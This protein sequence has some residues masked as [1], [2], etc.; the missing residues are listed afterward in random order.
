MIIGSVIGFVIL[1]I[2]ALVCCRKNKQ[3]ADSQAC[4]QCMGCCFMCCQCCCD[5]F[6]NNRRDGYVRKADNVRPAYTD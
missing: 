2:V 3:C 6:F 5:L 4:N 1:V